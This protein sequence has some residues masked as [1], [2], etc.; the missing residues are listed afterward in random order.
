MIEVHLLRYALAAAET[1]SFSQAAERF[2][3]KQSTLSKRIAYLEQRIGIALFSRST[4]GV[5]PTAG[6]LH[7]LQ[8]ARGIVDDLERLAR[9][10]QAL[11]CGRRGTLRIGFHAS[12]AGGDLRAILDAYREAFPQVALEAI[13]DGRAQLLDALDRDRLDLA[14]IAG[15]GDPGA[16]CALTVWSEP[17]MIAL[18]VGH[19]LA[20]SERLYWTDF[21]GMSFLVTRADP[22]SLIAA[23]IAAR[24]TGP[25]TIAK[26]AIQAVSRDNLPILA[27]ETRVAV[28]AGAAPATPKILWREVHDAFGATRLDQC[29]QWHSANPNPALAQFLALI[30]QR[31][32][33]N[34]PVIVTTGRKAATRG[35]A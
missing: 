21:R 15:E 9:E 7:F 29:M 30:E 5:A 28:L 11:A 20:S 8:K 32:R 16:R 2:C 6:G 17:L 33:P 23:M 19:R 12:L 26:I 13:E 34:R 4:Q 24:M 27:G 1:G 25:G 10:S 31:Y 35:G 18:P 22:G 3:V 14:I